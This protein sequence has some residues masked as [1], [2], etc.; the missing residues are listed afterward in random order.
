[1]PNQNGMFINSCLVHCQTEKSA[2][3]ANE[4][5]ALGNKTIAEAVGDWYFDRS[6][7]KVVDETCRHLALE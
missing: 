2:W 7:V 4:S 5:P 1:M 3:Y 6:E